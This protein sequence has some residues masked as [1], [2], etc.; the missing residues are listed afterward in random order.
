MSRTMQSMVAFVVIDLPAVGVTS[1]LHRLVV[2]EGAMF[3]RGHEVEGNRAGV[4]GLVGELM[5][6]ATT[7][8]IGSILTRT[9]GRPAPRI[10]GRLE[11]GHNVDMKW[12]RT[13]NAS[14]AMEQTEIQVGKW[15]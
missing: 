10:G 5:V 8:A 12:M 13:I 1:K 4:L 9:P 2:P 3:G 7:I 11:R 15:E 14:N 6:V